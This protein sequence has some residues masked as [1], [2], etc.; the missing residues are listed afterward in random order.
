MRRQPGGA[1]AWGRLAPGRTQRQRQQRGLAAA[2]RR[3][4]AGGTGGAG[5]SGSWEGTPRSC[6]LPA[7]RVAVPE[8]ALPLS[9]ALPL[10]SPFTLSPLD[11]AVTAANCG[12][13]AGC[14]DI[15]GFLVRGRTGG[16]SVHAGRAG[17][18]GAA[19]LAQPHAAPGAAFP[20]MCRPCCLLPVPTAGGRRLPQA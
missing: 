20:A 18:R 6:G 8:P 19:V 2:A 11:A 9:R 3:N 5:C 4:G 16:G 17:R 10:L 15:D 12:E 1:A 7:T 13:L 14:P